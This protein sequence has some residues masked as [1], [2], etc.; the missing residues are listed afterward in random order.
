MN[1]TDVAAGHGPIIL[2]AYATYVALDH[3]EGVTP[4]MIANAAGITDRILYTINKTAQA[5]EFAA[6]MNAVGSAR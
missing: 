4:K 5:D 2:A 6:R 1:G 3:M